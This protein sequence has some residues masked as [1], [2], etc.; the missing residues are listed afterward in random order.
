MKIK[1][2]FMWRPKFFSGW[3]L[4]ATKAVSTSLGADAKGASSGRGI[5]GDA[6]DAVM[7]LAAIRVHDNAR[8]PPTRR[9]IQ[10]SNLGFHPNASLTNR[11]PA[12][13]L[14][15]RQ[16]AHALANQ[17]CTNHQT[18]KGVLPCYRQLFPQ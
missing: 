10:R 3:F 7:P 12:R 5:A 9:G 2:L 18:K 8:A 13:I 16:S 17:A 14:P 11:L 4:T 6:S 15:G 1:D